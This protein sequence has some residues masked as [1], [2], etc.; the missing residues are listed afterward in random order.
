M[1]LAFLTNVKEE[2][3]CPICLELLRE[4][5]SLE[6]GHSFCQS[7]ITANHTKPTV[8]QEESCCPVCRVSYQPGSLRPNRHLA[9]IVERLREVNLSQEEGQKVDCCARHGEKLLLFCKKDGKVICWLCERSQEHRN[10]QTFLLEEVAKEY[11]EK[12]RVTLDELMKKQQTTEK[13]KVDIH[14]ERT[15]WK[16]QTQDEKE[17]VQGEFARLK[18]ILD[19]EE[20]IELQKLEDEEKEVLHS[21]EESENKL[22]QQNQLVKDLI[23]DLEHRLEGSTIKMLQDANDIMKRNKK[24][25]LNKPKTFPK[26]KKVF[27][28]PDLRG[29]LQVFKEL[30]DA[31]CYWAEMTF[32]TKNL[33]N[34]IMSMDQTQ[35][36]YKNKWTSSSSYYC[37][38]KD[39]GVLGELYI[40]SGR[41]YW[42]VDV[43]KKRA[44][45]LGVRLKSYLKPTMMSGM[46]DEK[47]QPQ[48]GYWV[49]GLQN[50]SEYKAYEDPSILTL[51]LTV[52]PCRVGVFV[53]YEAG[54]VSFFNVT[55][56][57]FL[58]YKFS[59]CDFS[60]GVFPYFNP[61]QC[62]VPMVL[63][64]PGS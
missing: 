48:Y 19:S 50:R 30:T 24:L 63:C 38:N 43:S 23:S 8:G 36:K 17:R 29:M 14:E 20:Q 11:Q 7:C 55:N 25:I 32:S 59:A 18:G 51:S 54:T 34:I 62:E 41:H 33:V 56:H 64:S 44:W 22:A 12:L 27:R 40:T 5:Q 6:C 4:P 49:I 42:E 60:E 53:D 9:N 1:A 2:V 15:S 45:I 61:C 13:W 57:G 10:H 52:P 3:T 16:N 47:Y 26:Q 46:Q 58:I 37:N 39:D 21:L 31:Q 28:A 35:L